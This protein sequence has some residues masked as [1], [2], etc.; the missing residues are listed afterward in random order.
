MHSDH[1]AP[2]PFWLRLILAM[3]VIGRMTR[4]LLYGDKDNIWYLLLTLVSLWGIAILQW[5]LLGLFLPALA[6]VPVVFVIL[7]LITVG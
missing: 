7:M 3:P 4:E 5:G 6:M 1:N 2:Q